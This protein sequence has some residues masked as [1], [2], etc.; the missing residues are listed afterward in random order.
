MATRVSGN[1]GVSRNCLWLGL[2]PPSCQVISR[3]TGSPDCE[4]SCNSGSY[5]P[6]SYKAVKWESFVIA[7]TRDVGGKACMILRTIATSEAAQSSAGQGRKPRWIQD[8]TPP[9]HRGA[10]KDAVTAG[11]EKGRPGRPI[12]YSKMNRGGFRPPDA[13]L[14]RRQ[15]AYRRR[16]AVRAACFPRESDRHPHR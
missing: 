10:P 9:A 13:R 5:P 2:S 16:S 7:G 11:H 6:N 1:H 14:A 12:P 15:T 3:Q 4:A 8:C